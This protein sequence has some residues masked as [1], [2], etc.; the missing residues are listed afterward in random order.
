MGTSIHA[1]K[2]VLCKDITPLDVTVQMKL[3]VISAQHIHKQTYIQTQL[4]MF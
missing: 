4:K 2:N 1:N 3:L